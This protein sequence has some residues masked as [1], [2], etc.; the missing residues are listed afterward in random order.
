MYNVYAMHICKFVSRA[1]VKHLFL[2]TDHAKLAHW[3]QELYARHRRKIL[4]SSGA[5]LGRKF[6]A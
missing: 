3:S 1:G 5:I 4:I 6:Y 2:V